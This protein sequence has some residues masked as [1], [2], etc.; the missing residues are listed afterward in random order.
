VNGSRGH[1]LIQEQE[2]IIEDKLKNTGNFDTCIKGLPAF[3]EF[4]LVKKRFLYLLNY[5]S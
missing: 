3:K 4:G 2:E 5:D 1:E